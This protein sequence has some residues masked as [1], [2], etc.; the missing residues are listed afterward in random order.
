MSGEH[1]HENYEEAILALNERVTALETVPI[2]PEPEPEPEPSKYLWQSDYTVVPWWK[3]HGVIN[4]AQPKSHELATT[5]VD[6]HE[7]G[8][9]VQ[10]DCLPG[11][12]LDGGGTCFGFV[13]RCSFA[14]LGLCESDAQ[15]LA[16]FY[17]KG[18][19][20]LP[21]DWGE[22]ENDLRWR[23]RTG[24][25]KLL[26]TFGSY[27]PAR[28]VMSQPFSNSFGPLAYA[29]S[30]SNIVKG[31]PSATD[32]DRDH[33]RPSTFFSVAQAGGQK[34][35]PTSTTMIQIYW[36]YNPNPKDF[37]GLGSAAKPFVMIER[38]KWHSF[39][40][41]IRVNSAGQ[42]NGEYKG[43][44]D[45]VL[46]M[47][48]TDLQLMPNIQRGVNVWHNQYFHGGPEGNDTKQTMYLGPAAF[49][50]SRLEDF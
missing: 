20:L 50:D 48:I 44:Y 42:A 17:W 36:H 2:P 1:R 13:D 28:G 38:G 21:A 16:E 32:Y 18:Y 30:I 35:T 3:N 46:A 7:Y 6:S 37:T 22:T 41:Y 31:P 5:I 15:G 45:N 12:E 9:V 19:F 25:Y 26:N 29:S 11:T 40:T 24:S 33:A 4:A 10:V 27:D 43:W 23:E 14:Q 8:P 47:H 49:N 39:E 34:R